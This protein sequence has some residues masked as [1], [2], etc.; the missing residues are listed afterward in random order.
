MF[1][2]SLK[3]R[4]TLILPIT[5]CIVFALLILLAHTLFERSQR[6]TV[7]AQQYLAVSVLADNIDQKLFSTRDIIVGLSR[8]LEPGIVADPGKALEFLRNRDEYLDVFDNGLFIFDNKGRM[9]AE[10][11]LGTSRTGMDFNFREYLKETLA[12]KKPYISDPYVSSR[13][14]HHPS[15]MFTA[16]LLDSSGRVVAVMGGSI[17][18]TRNNILGKIMTLKIGQA[19]YMFIFSESRV[20]ILHPD[21]N[22]VM[23]M[24]IPQGANKLLDQ[25]IAG[26]DGSGETV[27]SRGIPMLSSFRH[28]HAKPWIMGCQFSLA[29]GLSTGT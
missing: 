2:P 28:L 5:V 7:S 22:R 8:K 27:N 15:L 18:L 9:L 11:P 13:S 23:K 12:S 20:M 10:L 19:G 24:D 16:P 21:K 1:N 26:F 29:G 17:D 25:A 14:N 3:T 6:R 4:I